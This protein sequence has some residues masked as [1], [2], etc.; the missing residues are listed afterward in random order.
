VA[1]VSFSLHDNFTI[2]IINFVDFVNAFPLKINKNV[3]F[4]E[5]VVQPKAI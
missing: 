2:K 3:Y 5:V 4:V 1:A